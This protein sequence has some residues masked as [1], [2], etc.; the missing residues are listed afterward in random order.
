METTEATERP[1]ESVR[2]PSEVLN[3]VR[4][5]AKK[6]GRL[7]SRELERIILAGLKAEAQ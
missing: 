6:E 4:E 1:T 3:R 5:I 2:I 7:I